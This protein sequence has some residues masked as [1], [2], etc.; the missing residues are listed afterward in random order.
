MLVN[1]AREAGISVPDDPENYDTEVYPHW[2]VYCSVQLGSP[3]PNWS[4]HWENARVVS[5][6]P[7]SEITSITLEQLLERG[8]Q[9][10]HSEP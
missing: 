10:G 5:H 7:L 1:P 4:C 8:L 6:V 3:M 9:I 2:N